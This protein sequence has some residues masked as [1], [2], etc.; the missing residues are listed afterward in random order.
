MYHLRKSEFVFYSV[1]NSTAKISFVIK[2]WTCLCS[3]ISKTLLLRQ[4]RKNCNESTIKKSYHNVSKQNFMQKQAGLGSQF[5]ILNCW[6]RAELG[7]FKNKCEN[8]NTTQTNLAFSV[9]YV[10][11]TLTKEVNLAVYP[12]CMGGCVEFPITTRFRH[13]IAWI[14]Q[15]DD[16]STVRSAAVLSAYALFPR[17]LKHNTTNIKSSRM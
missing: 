7:P 6:E 13:I 15:G 1:Q 5:E 8:S 10:C 2:A 11:A 9:P 4:R 16:A 12:S 3:I 17:F 14:L